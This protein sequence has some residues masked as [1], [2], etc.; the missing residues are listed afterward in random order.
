MER[1]FLRSAAFGLLWVALIAEAVWIVLNVSR[2]IGEL[3]RPLI[4]TGGFLL[5]AAGRG[6]TGWIGLLG[7]LV[8][9]GAFLSALPGRFSNWPGFV[10]FAGNVNSFLPQ[11]V[12]PAVAVVATV[13][14]CVLCAAILLGIKTRWSAVGSGVLLFFFATA[15][16]ISGLSQAE[17][18]V[19]VLS[20]GAFAL[21]TIDASF[22]SVDRLLASPRGPITVRG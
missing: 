4:F 2:P 5:V 15:M 16:A 14:E 11:E 19:Y 10:R 13:M 8:V 22:L 7:R 3:A 17:W 9:A 6:T 12:V 18:A 20:A 21:A 1:S